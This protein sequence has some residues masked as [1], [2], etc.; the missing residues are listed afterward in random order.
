[1]FVLAVMAAVVPAMVALPMLWFGDWSAKTR[2][3][4][5]L[6]IVGGSIGFAAAVRARVARPLQTLANL[7]AAVARATTRCEGGAARAMT[8][9]RWRWAK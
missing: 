4:L 1:M 7:I 5:T 6:F 8:R 2:W 9:W 3:T